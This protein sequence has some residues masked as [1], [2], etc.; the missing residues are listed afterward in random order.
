MQLSESELR[1]LIMALEV[2]SVFS[3]EDGAKRCRALIKRL[4]AELRPEGM[5]PR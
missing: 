3:S 4:E 2:A 1:D 5:D